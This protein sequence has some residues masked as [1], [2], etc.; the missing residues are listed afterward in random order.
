[1]DGQVDVLHIWVSM[2]LEEL[3]VEV[4][5]SSVVQ[6]YVRLWQELLAREVRVK[7]PIGL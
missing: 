6:E 5:R 4:E 7:I 3:W 2:D 1:M